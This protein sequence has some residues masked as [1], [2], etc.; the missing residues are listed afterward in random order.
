MSESKNTTTGASGTTLLQI[1]FIVLKLCNVITW[2]WWWV[3][4]PTWIS[5]GLVVLALLIYG[6]YLW[7]KSIDTKKRLAAGMNEWAWKRRNKKN[8]ETEPPII[9]SRFQQRVEEMQKR[10]KNAQRN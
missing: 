10:N 3:M 8:S 2:S 4:S 1:A 5:I 6:I 9:K 7:R